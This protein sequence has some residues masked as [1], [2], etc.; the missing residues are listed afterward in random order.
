MI[1]FDDVVKNIKEHNPDQPQE[2]P[3]HPCRI[4][5]IVRSGCGK[6]NSLFNL[7]NQQCDIDKIYLYTKDPY[8]VKYEFFMNK[9]ESTGLNHF[10]DSKAFIEHS[11]NMSTFIKTSKIII[12]IYRTNKDDIDSI[13]QNHKE[14]IESNKSI[15]KTQQKFKSES[16]NV[17]TEEIN[18]IASNSKDY[19]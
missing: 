7:I 9:R 4:L 8:E 14:F 3:D 13:K 11:V 10:N 17:F 6:T 18:N 12:Q 1:N 19:K 5:I 2:Y 15:L 16:N